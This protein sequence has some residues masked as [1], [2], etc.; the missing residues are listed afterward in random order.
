MA[1][2]TS[3]GRP[4]ALLGEEVLTPGA[5]LPPVPHDPLGAGEA[6]QQQVPVALG[7]HPTVQ[8]NDD[9]G[10]LAAADQAAKPLFQLECR[11]RKQIVHEPVEPLLREAL[12]SRSR[13]RLR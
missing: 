3:Y 1:A 9:T 4:D 5:H 10:V 13:E 2:M 6:A 11:V 7:D 12:Q 8:Q